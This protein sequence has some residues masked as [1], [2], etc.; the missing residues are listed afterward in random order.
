MS[1]NVFITFDRRK[2]EQFRKAYNRARAAGETQ[3]VFEGHS[4]LVAYARYMLEY[5]DLRVVK[6]RA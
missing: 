1:E 2:V 3:F 5:L 6:E 4:L